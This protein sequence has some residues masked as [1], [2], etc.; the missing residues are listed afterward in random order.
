MC[1]LNRA[2][3]WGVALVLAFVPMVVLWER[4]SG[5]LARATLT[6]PCLPRQAASEVAVVVG[7]QWCMAFGYVSVGGGLLKL[8]RARSAEAEAEAPSKAGEAPPCP[9][10]AVE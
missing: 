2:I 5:C 6:R 4:S 10:V 9:L 8:C 1:C 3:V 7:L